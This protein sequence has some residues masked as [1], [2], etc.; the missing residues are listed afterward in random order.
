MHR[1]TPIA[2]ITLLGFLALDVSSNPV[3]ALGH[4]YLGA[5][6]KT[7]IKTTCDRVSGTYF[8]GGGMYGCWGKGGDV[9]CT[10]Q[11]KTCVG[12]C[13]KC[14]QRIQ[15]LGGLS[16][17]LASGSWFPEFAPPSAGRVRRPINPYGPYV[18]PYVV[19]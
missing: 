14:G 9:N 15:D 5:H 2:I 17:I 11:T 4:V 1:H 6:S 12:T 18:V 8:E 19:R 10:N 7:E 16:G 13:E 3:F